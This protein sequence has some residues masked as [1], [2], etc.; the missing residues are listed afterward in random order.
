MLHFTKQNTRSVHSE[1]SLTRLVCLLEYRVIIG[2]HNHFETLNLDGVHD[3]GCLVLQSDH[4]GA[5]SNAKAGKTGMC[6]NEKAR[7][8]TELGR[9]RLFT[10]LSKDSSRDVCT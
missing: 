8:E 5:I 4:A 3:S 9:A 1:T 10:T 7:L 2:Y 6:V